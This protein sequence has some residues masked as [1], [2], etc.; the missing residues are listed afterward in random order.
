MSI[1]TIWSVFLNPVT[2]TVHNRY[3][4]HH[5]HNGSRDATS[6]RGASFSNQPSCAISS[7]K[8][9]I[10]GSRKRKLEDMYN[11]CAGIQEKQICTLE[12]LLLCYWP[13]PVTNEAI[14]IVIFVCKNCPTSIAVS[15]CI[16][17]V[18]CML[19]INVVCISNVMC[20]LCI[21]VVCIS[22]VMCMLC[23]NVVC[24]SNVMCMLCINVVSAGI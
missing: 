2:Y 14:S 16:S 9:I 23:I 12:Y 24:I 4:L 3:G 5:C 6:G 21:N 22:N 8:P 11:Y 18:M 15:M 1:V 13:V 7:T 17:N 20:M 10:S 19:C